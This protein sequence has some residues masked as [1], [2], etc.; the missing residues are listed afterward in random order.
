M[1]DRTVPRAALPWPRVTLVRCAIR[2]PDDLGYG[3]F[4]GVSNNTW[5]FWCLD[6]ARASLDYV[7]EDDAELWR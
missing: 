6:D 1:I 3:I 5:R 4:Y 2:A 7:P